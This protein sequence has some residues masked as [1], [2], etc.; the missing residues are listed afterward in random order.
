MPDLP[1]I[2]S[3]VVAGFAVLEKGSQSDTLFLLKSTKEQSDSVYFIPFSDAGNGKKSYGGGR[4]L[5]IVHRRGK[6]LLLDF[7]YASNPYCAYRSDFVCP[8]VPAFNRIKWE[9]LAGEK[10]FPHQPEFGIKKTQTAIAADLISR[11]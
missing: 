6:A 4:Y 3:H 10:I 8:R 1:G 9:I 11:K 2:P 7:N 5:D